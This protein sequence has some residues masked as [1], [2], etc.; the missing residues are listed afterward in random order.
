MAINLNKKFTSIAALALLVIGLV[1][2]GFVMEDRYNNQVD[3]DKSISVE[4]KVTTL[5]FEKIEQSLVMNLKQFQLEQK[6]SMDSQQRVN[7]Y[8]YYSDVLN[9]IRLQLSKLR[10]ELRDNPD[11]QDIREDYRN[12][13][14]REKEVKNKLDN[15]LD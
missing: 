2:S 8:R 10:Q 12:L 6:V 7:D 1:T 3:H 15:L 11:N 13:K 5:E 4:R 9:N 14:I